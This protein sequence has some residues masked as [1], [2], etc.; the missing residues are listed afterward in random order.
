MMSKTLN[1]WF[2]KPVDASS[3]AVFRIMFGALLLFDS[4]NYGIFLCL[5][6]M[7]R[8]TSL[9]FKYAFFEWVALPPGA[10][11]EML[12]VVMGVCAFCIMIG[13][14]Y[15][16]AIVVYTIAFA[17]FF[18]LDQG[19]YLNHFYLL[20]IYSAIL[21]FVPANRH[22]SVDALRRPAWASAMIP[23]WGR[24]WLCA[25]TEIVL[26]YAGFVKLNYD[27]LNLEPMRLWM[28][29]LS[30]DEIQLFQWLT[31]DWGIALASY[32]AIALHL[33]GAPLLLWKKTRLGVFLLYCLFHFTNA[34][35][36]NIGIFPF[37]TIAATL[38]LFDP[39]WPRQVARWLQRR[40]VSHGK[41][42]ARPDTSARSQGTIG[43]WLAVLSRAPEQS[44]RWPALQVT[45]QRR[46]LIIAGVCLWLAIQ[47]VV[48]LRHFAA[49]GNV[50][51]NEDG[52]RFSWRMK[53]RSK[54]GEAVFVAIREDGRRW[55]VNPADHLNTKQAFSMACIPDMLWQ[56]AHYVEALY[57]EEGRLDV[58][59]YV[60]A[61]C[62][63][64][65]REP[66]PLTRRMVDL[67]SVKRS[68]PVTDWITPLT[69]PL[70]R[71][72]F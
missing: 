7:Y 15:R 12:F 51:W 31:Q 30:H 48:P 36:F 44:R 23:N 2:F 21:M 55:V 67:T 24:L 47:V 5:D 69:T 17:W 20:L 1:H 6:C 46:A 52:H 38:I 18:L 60:D 26:L 61:R 59:V 11:L 56:F 4:I 42:E 62:S 58:A 49:P 39:D 34:M 13:L 3:L 65:A 50:A 25:Q 14:F 19:Q 57:S 71:P 33:I 70:P 64:N 41:S 22:L 35:V 40:K 32:G 16:I 63:L 37:M 28:N 66:A 72:L 9:L 43:R 10:G 45:D 53:L 68:D 29:E 54:E 27:W 8:D